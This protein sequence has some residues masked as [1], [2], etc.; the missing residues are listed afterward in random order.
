MRSVYGVKCAAKNT[1][2]RGQ[3][4]LPTMNHEKVTTWNI[5]TENQA[6]EYVKS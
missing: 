2:P 5:E 6:N 1:K 3:L 4:V